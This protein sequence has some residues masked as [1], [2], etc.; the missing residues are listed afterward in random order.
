[1]KPL[2]AAPEEEPLDW[3]RELRDLSQADSASALRAGREA[4]VA[5]KNTSA[6]VQETSST[7]IPEVGEVVSWIDWR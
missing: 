5:E 6:T 4:M 1:M 7:K 2:E 3:R